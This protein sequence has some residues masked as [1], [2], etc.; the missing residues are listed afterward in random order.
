MKVFEQEIWFEPLYDNESFITKRMFGGMAI[1]F[2]GL[3]VAV[4]VENE[5]DRNYRG[6]VFEF[7]IWSGV[8]WPTDRV[9]H[10]SLQNEFPEL[11]SHP[12][13]GKWLYLPA[14]CERF[15]E[16]VSRI[17]ARIRLGD[18]RLG[19]VPKRRP[20]VA[21]HRRSRTKK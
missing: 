6:K 18:P 4:L 12:V 21:R 16:T 20:S 14:G 10:L 11:V 5:G 17:V 19:I 7:D 8:M 1:Y 3:M 9:H 15:E 13:L 2:E